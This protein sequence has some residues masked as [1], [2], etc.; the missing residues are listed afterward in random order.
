MT[1]KSKE[2]ANP[3]YIDGEYDESW[4]ENKKGIYTIVKTARQVFPNNPRI[5]ISDLGRHS[6]ITDLDV[7]VFQFNNETWRLFVGEDHLS[8]YKDDDNEL[9]YS[10]GTFRIMKSQF[11]MGCTGLLSNMGS[12][13]LK[14]YQ[15]TAYRVS[16]KEQWIIA[17]LNEGTIV[18]AAIGND[19]NYEVHH[20]EGR[21]VELPNSA[22][23]LITIPID[24]HR[25][26]TQLFQRDHNQFVLVGEE[27][28]ANPRLA[29]YKASEVIK[30]PVLLKYQYCSNIRI[31]DYVREILRIVHEQLDNE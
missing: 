1:R 14:L 9:V 29:K 23:N 4:V 25:Y 10:K 30:N 12:A 20:V 31:R 7:G 3:F 16:L 13:G 24:L 2:I 15:N 21:G 17:A 22:S 8:L 6:I 5:F 27:F 19:R 26:V 11:L 18:L 28:I